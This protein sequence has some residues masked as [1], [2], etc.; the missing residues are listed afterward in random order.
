MRQDDGALLALLALPLAALLFRRGWLA[1]LATLALALP[2]QESLAF[3]WID[4][5]RRADQ[6]AAEAFAQGRTGEEALLAERLD[7]DSPWRALLFYRAGR[8]A[9]AEALFA[10]HDTADA[11]YNRG[12]AL[13]LAGRLEAALEAYAAA[14]ERSPGMRDAIH[15]RALVRAALAKQRAQGAGDEE[16]QA[17]EGAGERPRPRSRSD[18]GARGQERE[19]AWDE[20]D[21]PKEA[22]T[23]D[24]PRAARED[25]TES[26]ERAERQRLEQLL[27]NVPDDPGSLLANRF[28]HHMRQ[29]STPHRDTGARW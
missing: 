4:L 11:H 27:A 7:R 15:N 19:R 29:R 6:Q 18:A 9:E 12:N 26:R 20:P 28:A 17:P 21:L 8:Y 22:Q 3:E 13:A 14:L 2:S 1:C 23:R 5:W 25:S 24:T 10:A 16:S